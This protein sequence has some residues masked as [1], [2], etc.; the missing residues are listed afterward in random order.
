MGK[1]YDDLLRKNA[2]IRG[3]RWTKDGKKE[4]ST[5]TRGKNFFLEKREGQKYHILGKYTPLWEGG[6]TSAHRA[7]RT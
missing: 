1:K 7:H 6:I 2:N 3:K 5:E 4:I